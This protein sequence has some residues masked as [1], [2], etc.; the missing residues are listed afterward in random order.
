[1]EKLPEKVF[2]S[3]ANRLGSCFEMCDFKTAF[4]LPLRGFFLQQGFQ[5]DMAVVDERFRPT[6]NAEDI[7]YGQDYEQQSEA[8]SHQVT[9]KT[10]YKRADGAADYGCAQDS[11]EGT[12]VAGDGIERKGIYYRVHD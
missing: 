4:F 9:Q 2:T 8:Q 12:L 1:M 11:C 5:I 7:S 10:D 3:T 6:A